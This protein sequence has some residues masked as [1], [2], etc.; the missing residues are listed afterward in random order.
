MIAYYQGSEAAGAACRVCQSAVTNGCDGSAS[1]I[2]TLHNSLSKPRRKLRYS[3]G[4][5]ADGTREDPPESGAAVRISE[6]RFETTV[7]F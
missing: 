2:M 4:H 7:V 3:N 6:E 5:L 1:L